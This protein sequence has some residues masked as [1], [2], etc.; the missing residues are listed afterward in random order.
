MQE[1]HK[2]DRGGNLY[3]KT[4]AHKTLRDGFYWPT[5][6]SNTYKEVSSCHECQIFEGKRKLLPMLLNPI[7][8]EAPFQQRGL[9][10][11]GEINPTSS[12]QH[13]WILIA[14]YYFTKWIEVVPTQQATYVVIIELLINNILSRFGCP[15]KI[16][17]NNAK[18]FTS[19][20]L[21]KFCNDYNIILSH[22]LPPGKWSCRFFK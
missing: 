5:L 12:G 13:K 18:A 8:I 22:S 17:T 2:G 16:I 21:V 6:F 7:S 4:I 15:R 9:D 3:W 1:F 14:T 20:K 11:I 19:S 10:F